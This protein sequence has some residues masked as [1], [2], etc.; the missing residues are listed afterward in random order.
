MQSPR[1]SI[2]SKIKKPLPAIFH[3][4]NH[5]RFRILRWRARRKKILNYTT[6]N[7]QHSL[8][9]YFNFQRHI[10]SFMHKFNYSL[11]QGDLEN[12]FA[13]ISKSSLGA[14]PNSNNASYF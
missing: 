6:A 13:S 14:L 3:L 2:N 4:K 8:Q 5:V 11:V 10:N 1:R 12:N 9:V 7:K